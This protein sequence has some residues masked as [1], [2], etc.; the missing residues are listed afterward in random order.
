MSDY[1]AHTVA[2]WLGGS[3]NHAITVCAGLGRGKENSKEKLLT[4]DMVCCQIQIARARPRQHMSIVKAGWASVT[5]SLLRAALS[6]LI[7]CLE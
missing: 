3:A 1:D 5:M 6:S 7:I 4:R 2:N